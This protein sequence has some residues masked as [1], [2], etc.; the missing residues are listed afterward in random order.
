MDL[1]ILRNQLKMRRDMLIRCLLSKEQIT[2]E[3]L[4]KG[5]K[6]SRIIEIMERERFEAKL[7]EVQSLLRMIGG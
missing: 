1:D 5:I 6:G 7:L 3:E 4:L 2:D